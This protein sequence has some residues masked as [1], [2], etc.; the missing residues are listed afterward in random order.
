VFV[1]DDQFRLLWS[2][3]ARQYLFASETA[4]PRLE[5]LVGHDRLHTIARSGG[6]ALF[7]NQS[8]R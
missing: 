4:I 3:T 8:L 2:G 6:K 5:N 1:D 7:S